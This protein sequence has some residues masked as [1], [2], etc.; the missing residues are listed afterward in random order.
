MIHFHLK[1][2][3]HGRLD[4]R[5]GGASIDTEGQQLVSVLRLFLRDQRLLGDHR[6]LDNV[7]NRTHIYAVSFLRLGAAFAGFSVAF[8]VRFGFA[9]ADGAASTTFS[10]DTSP[11]FSLFGPRSCSSSLTAASE[12]INC[13]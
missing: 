4:L 10:V 5:L 11:P 8:R 13:S 9:S 7:P 1:D 3:F 6:R 12:I 2:R